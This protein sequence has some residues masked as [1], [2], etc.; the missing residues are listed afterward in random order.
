MPKKRV[1]REIELPLVDLLEN[2]QKIDLLS[3]E[4]PFIIPGYIKNNLK[5]QLRPYQE[6]A[7]VNLDWTQHQASADYQ[8][9][10]LLFD[11]ATGSGKTDVL[12]A[13]ILYLYTEFS[14]HNFLFVVNTNAV[15][16]KTYDN[17][18][19]ID[20]SKYLFSQPINIH[21]QK[22]EIRPVTQFSQNP[23]LGVI[24]LRL[25]T[26]QTLANELS[27]V[28]ENGLTY[29]DFTKQKLIVLADEAHHFSAGTKSKQDQKDR[30]W[31]NIL[32]RIRQCNKKNRQFEFTATLDLQNEDIYQKYREKIVYRY[33]LSQFIYE[34]YSK[35]VYRLQANNDDKDKMMNV[36]LL[37]QYRKRIAQS[38]NIPDFKPVILFKSNKIAIS[39]EARKNFLDLIDHLNV[40]D[41]TK[42]LKYQQKISH[43]QALK[44]A[45]VYWLSQDLATAIVELKHDFQALNTINVNDSAKEGILGDLND[46]HNLNTL[47]NNDNPFRVIFAVAKLSE[48][49]DVLNLY[50]IVRIGEQPTTLNQTNSEAQ[51]I[52]RGARYYPFVYQGKISYTRRFDGQNTKYQLLESIYYHTINDPKY[53]ENLKKSL[54][55]L[56][57]P[58]EDDSDFD[59]YEANVKSTFKKSKVYQQG[60]IYFNEIESIPDKEFNGI[61][62]YGINTETIAEVNLVD[63]TWETSYNA[64][65]TEKDVL[66]ETR[67][68]FNFRDNLSLVKKAFSRNKF[69]RF[70]SLHQYVPTLKSLNEF[71]LSDNWLGKIRLYARVA[72][73]S[74]ELNREQQLKA[75]EQYLTFVQKQII[76]NYQRKRGTNRFIPVPT[77][78]LIKDYQKKVSKSFN[79]PISERILPYPM[80]NK[81]WYVFDEAI[82]DGLE[83]SAIDFIGDFINR[84]Q[85][86]YEYIYLFRND[87]QNTNFKLHQFKGQISHYEGFM[88][89]FILYLQNKDFCYQIYIEPKGPQL[90]DRDHWKQ[91]L[92]ES[93]RPEN[94]EVIGENDHVK[95]YGLKFFTN[96]DGENIGQELMTIKPSGK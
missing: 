73:D 23:E 20:S 57:L 69:Y 35:R 96:G 41:L 19:K 79:K 60:K 15:V 7:L 86:K 82:V 26:I 66:T 36:V 34:G 5:H 29:N 74:P 91:D 52:G 51:L 9:N 49:W 67:F 76:N 94:I 58:V 14:Y 89:D 21:G 84:L 72:N 62:R 77:K 88:P 42:F 18:L 31:E 40:T 12:A 44:Q 54:D 46:L 87:E 16:A 6:Q 47:E 56:N 70:N 30:S 95:L 10:Q 65:V 85:E 78:S 8:Y 53:L 33:D 48:G 68:L 25:T 59:V 11:M 61:D 37:S 3:D 24:Y 28:R 80:E 43:S 38:L 55:K 90:L 93:I 45:Y 50:D 81:P 17:L 1:L 63:S 4:E 27:T 75:V 71:I 22:I 32:D 39:K 92:L 64:K 2:K 83:K 13:M